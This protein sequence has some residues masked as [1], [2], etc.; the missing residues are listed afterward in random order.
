MTIKASTEWPC[1]LLPITEAK[2]GTRASTNA[3]YGAGHHQVARAA[4]SSSPPP[5]AVAPV[6]GGI[7]SRRLRGW[8]EID[9][10]VREILFDADQAVLR[11]DLRISNGGTGLARDIAIEAVTTNAGEDQAAALAAFLSGRAVRRSP[12]RSS[13]HSASRRSAMTTHAARRHPRL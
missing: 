12:S 5:Q 3:S 7:V 9:L 1:P 2:A 8:V 4:G 6:T 13:G 11:V 10:G